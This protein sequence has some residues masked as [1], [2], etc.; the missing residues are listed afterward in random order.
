MK[1]LNNLYMILIHFCKNKYSE[2]I[3]LDKKD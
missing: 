1:D 2:P 3:I